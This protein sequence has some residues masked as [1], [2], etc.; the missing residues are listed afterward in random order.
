[1]FREEMTMLKKSLVALAILG[2][3]SIGSAQWNEV[4]DAGQMIGTAQTVGGVGA[5]TTIRGTINGIA[6]VDMYRI[7]I[8]S[9]TL[10]SA[11]TEA[12]GFTMSDTQLFLF[13]GS[14]NGIAFNDDI[15]TNNGNFR[16]RLNQG[17]SLYASLPAG[18]YYLAVSE[19][20][21]DPFWRIN[22]PNNDYIFPFTGDGGV[23]IGPFSGAGP[24]I[25][26]DDDFGLSGGTYQITLT[27]VSAVPEPATMVALGLGAAALLRRRKKA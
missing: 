9:P 16:S 26:W 11:H 2:V 15:D 20:D 21:N 6:D 27:G 4:G 3:A 7:Q 1:M 10:F 17:N 5:I 12:A 24:L 22:S 25:G 13:N 23:G 14:G 8:S 18:I 19:F